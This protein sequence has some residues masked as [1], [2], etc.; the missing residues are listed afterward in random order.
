MGLNLGNNAINN[1]KLGNTQVTKVYKGN[2]LVWPVS[3]DLEN[4]F[5]NALISDRYNN[6]T[7]ANNILITAHDAVNK[8]IEINSPEA[9]A[10]M[11]ANPTGTGGE[12]WFICQGGEASIL[13][14]VTSISSLGTNRLYYGATY[15]GSPNFSV[16]Q[17]VELFNPFINYQYIPNNNPLFNPYPST[18]SGGSFHY[19]Q[20]GGIYQKTNGTYVMLCPVVYGAH[21]ERKIYY[22]TSPD[23]ENWTF[24]DTLLLQTS[25]ISFAKTTGNVF[26]TSNPFKMNDGKYLVLL[27]VQKPDNNYTSAYMIMDEDL[28]ITT[29]PT[30]IN[31]N[32]SNFN[33]TNHYPLSLVYHDGKF[34]IIIHNRDNGTDINK[35]CWE[36]VLTASNTDANLLSLLNATSSAPSATKIQDANVDSG[37]LNGKMDDAEYIQN[38]NSLFLII[39]SEEENVGGWATSNN[40]EY[41]LAKLVG[42]SWVHDVRSPM[43]VNPMQLHNKYPQFNFAWDHFGG[44]I[45]P[46]VKNGWLYMFIASGDDGAQDY[47]MSGIKTQ[48]ITQ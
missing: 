44:Y 17:K 48:L 29:S 15:L 20:P 43:I 35:E 47:W 26:S 42:N 31:I 16:G 36:Y 21:V 6:I 13:V 2:D 28:N 33:F 9:H 41:G 8:Y 38:E 34:R 37:Y 18:V 45:S 30:E 10:A 27:A 46:I 40:R 24:T 14:E 7:R 11:A 25:S 22:A 5:K 3:F 32:S 39:G 4:S 1:L 12:S 19:I 23:L